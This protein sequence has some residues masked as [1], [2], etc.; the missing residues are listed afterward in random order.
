MELHVCVQE[1]VKCHLNVFIK[2]T[3]LYGL[4]LQ[5]FELKLVLIFL[6]FSKVLHLF[7]V[8]EMI[9]HF[10][11]PTTSLNFCHAH[12]K[13][14]KNPYRNLRHVNVCKSYIIKQVHICISCMKKCCIFQ[15][16]QSFEIQI[17]SNITT[18]LYMFIYGHVH[19]CRYNQT[20]S[21][22]QQNECKLILDK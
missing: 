1:C 10:I 2:A 5:A 15:K 13:I 11:P 14:K 16:F 3:L 8:F 21:E 20:E 4:M 9:P 6:V 18:I 7:L 12:G 19:Q 22:H 17:C